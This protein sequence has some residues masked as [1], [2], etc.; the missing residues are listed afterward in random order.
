MSK[1]RNLAY[2]G[3]GLILLGIVVGFVGFAML[4]FNPKKLGNTKI[5]HKTFTSSDEF[6]SIVI[7]SE[8]SDVKIKRSEDGKFRVDYD[9]ISKMRT[10]VVIE[11][12]VLKITEKDNRRW[13]DYILT[14]NFVSFN[15]SDIVVYLPE[16]Q[17]REV[18]VSVDTGSIKLYS[19]P[20]DGNIALKTDTGSIDVY[21]LSCDSISAETDTGSIDL[22]AVRVWN[23]VKLST[24]TGSIDIIDTI[25]DGDLNAR[26]DTGSVKLKD[27][28]ANSITVKT[29]TGSIKGTIL[30]EKIIFAKSDTGSVNVPES[31]TGGKCNLTTDTGSIKISYSK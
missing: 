14:F 22:E 12:G 1:N 3:L 20:V 16:K 15:N 31:L 8:V 5:E 11:D 2:T 26:T 21:N 27:I 7:K 4:G 13:Y 10:T 6:D 28:D 19:V 17:Y 24:D 23:G 9:R 18:N 30:T 25:A 29:D